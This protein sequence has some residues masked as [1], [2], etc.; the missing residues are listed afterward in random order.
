MR[1]DVA[2]Y[3]AEDVTT[4]ELSEFSWNELTIVVA[5]RRGRDHLPGV[6]YTGVDYDRKAI[7]VTFFENASKEERESVVH[8]AQR[9]PRV[10]R[11]AFEV[12][13]ADAES[14]T[15]PPPETARPAGMRCVRGA[16]G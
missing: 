11:V 2:I 12:V 8:L 3:F 15:T 1:V 4:G 6:Q 5:G 14:L 9:A 7:Y 16:S 13:P 10:E